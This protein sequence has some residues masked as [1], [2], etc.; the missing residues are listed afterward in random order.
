M[1]R[2]T[3]RRSATD[4]SSASVTVAPLPAC[5]SLIARC[6]YDR[7]HLAVTLR[8]IQKVTETRHKREAD[9]HTLRMTKHVRFAATACFPTYLFSRQIY[10]P[11]RDVYF[12]LFAARR[13][14]RSLRRL[15]EIS[16]SFRFLPRRLRRRRYFAARSHHYHGYPAAAADAV[17]LLLL[18]S[19]CV[20]LLCLFFSKLTAVP[21]SPATAISDSSARQDQIQRCQQN[22]R[23]THLK[24]ASQLLQDLELFDCKS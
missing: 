4:L 22:G 9:Y 11:S 23:V 6:R 10:C 19:A 17:F 1:P 2:S 18:L 12:P 20:D 3:S 8:G 5:S 15:K 16:T 24:S 21:F 13:V 14:R 7:N